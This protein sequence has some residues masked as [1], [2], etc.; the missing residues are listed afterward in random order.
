MGFI[1]L[2]QKLNRFGVAVE[3]CAATENHAVAAIGLHGSQ[4]VAG[5]A[6]IHVPVAQGISH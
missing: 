2:I 4:Q 5:A 3:G 6:E 1:L